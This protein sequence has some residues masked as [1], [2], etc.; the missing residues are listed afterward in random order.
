MPNDTVLGEGE[1]GA[2]AI[3]KNNNKTITMKKIIF[4]ATIAAVGLFASCKGGSTKASLKTDIDTVSYELGLANSQ[5]LSTY[6]EQE[7]IDSAQIKDFLRGIKDGITKSGKK[8]ERAY[9]LGLQ[10]GLNMY[11]NMVKPSSQQLFGGDSTKQLSAKNL[12]AGLVAGAN[13]K[14]ALKINGKVIDPQA[15]GQDVNERIQVLTAKSLEKKYG[16]QKAEN[17]KKLKE[18]VSKLGLKSLGKGV[19]YKENVA[20]TGAKAKITDAVEVDYE[21]SLIDGT[22][23]EDSKKNGSGQPARL[24]LQ[25][26]IPGLQTALTQ[27]PAG[28]DW[29]IYVS[30]DQAYGAQG[31]GPQIQPFTNLKFHIVNHGVKAA[32]AQPETGKAGSNN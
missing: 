12:V 20:G 15:A 30:Y 8:K 19:Y 21:L 3:V 27:M 10:A 9:Y 25:Q 2:K 26:I 6:L 13:N 22:V 23:I 7:G 32:N 16:A 1:H 5:G 24:S 28:A 29:D 31:A 14:S 18:T 4:A 17:D 11:Q